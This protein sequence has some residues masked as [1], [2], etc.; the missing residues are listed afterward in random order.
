[1]RI[2]IFGLAV[3]SSWGNGHASLWRGLI[4]ALL[5]DGHRVVFF[6]RDVPYYAEHRDFSRLPEGGELV[7]YRDWGD[8]LARAG[9]ALAEADVGMVTSYCPDGI[10]ATR[11]VCDSRVGVRCFYDL[12]TPITLARSAE[13]SSRPKAATTPPQSARMRHQSRMEPSW[14]PQVP[15]IL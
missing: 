13:G 2:V 14:F 15:V 10:A 7:L 4:A 9:Q 3:S 1:M 8:A 12:D 6:E 5:R 11:L